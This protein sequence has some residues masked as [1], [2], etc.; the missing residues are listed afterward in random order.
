[1]KFIFPFFL[2]VFAQTAQG[3][4]D[5][6]HWSDSLRTTYANPETTIMSAKEMEGFKGLIFFPYNPVSIV[7]ARF[8]RVKKGR[9]FMMKTSTERTP[10]YKVYGILTFTLD[11]KKQKLELYQNVDAKRKPG[12]ED[13]LFLP[14]TDETGGTESY[15]GGRYLDLR[16]SDV[17]KEMTLDFNFCYNPYCAYSAKYSCPVPPAQNHITA[18]VRAGVAYE[19]K[20]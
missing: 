11:G 6:Q 7:K 10:V 8:K 17:K 14:F 1:M 4:K 5:W 9:E 16:I 3:Q 18:P 12:Y 19:Q 2:L 20:Q 15:G 13:Y